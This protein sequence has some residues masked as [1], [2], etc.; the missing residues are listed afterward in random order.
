VEPQPHNPTPARNVRPVEPHR[1]FL[2]R[3]NPF[4][5][6]RSDGKKPPPTTP[7]L[8]T[9]ERRASEPQDAAAAHLGPT[10]NNVV[11]TRYAYRSPPRPAPGNRVEAQ[12]LFDQGVRA[13]QGHRLVEAVQSYNQATQM[14]PS[15]FEAHYNLGLTAAET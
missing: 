7:L 12:P 2:E 11:M 9:A 6:L 8:S 15:F 14:D 13:Q 10:S 1:G 4:N 3:I 5:W